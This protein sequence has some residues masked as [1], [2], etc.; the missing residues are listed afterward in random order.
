MG[1]TTALG[2][3]GV[4]PAVAIDPATEQLV[5]DVLRGRDG[6][7]RVRF[8]V[9]GESVSMEVLEH[10]RPTPPTDTVPFS[11]WMLQVLHSRGLSQEAAAQ[12]LGVS[13]KTVNRWVNG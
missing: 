10:E 8:R 12:H 1:P 13:H 11:A 3:S 9:T 7:V 6:E 2:A 5:R 4:M